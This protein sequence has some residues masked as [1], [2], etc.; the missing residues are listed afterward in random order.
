MDWVPDLI[1]IPPRRERN[2][3]HQ[4][5]KT[6]GVEKRRLV[7]QSES[8]LANAIEIET[9]RP[10]EKG[11]V[12]KPVEIESENQKRQTESDEKRETDEIS[13]KRETE[14]EIVAL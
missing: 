7:E 10:V 13:E 2:G 1:G 3:G 9:Q 8:E 6:I 12:Q 11:G 4:T 5:Q 14:S